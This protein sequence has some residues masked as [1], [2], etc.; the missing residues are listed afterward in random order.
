MQWSEVTKVPPRRQLRQFAVLCLVFFGGMTAWRAWRGH[1]GTVSEIVGVLGVAVGVVGAIA[2]AA[3]R[4]IYTGWM[5]AVFPIGWVVSRVILAA[6]YFIVFTP[7]AFVFR[8]IG[9]DALRLR[10]ASEART[11]WLEKSAPADGQ[12]YFRQF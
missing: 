2:P 3:I 1:L 9:R 8:L 6:L 11:L 4:W 12:A 10:R 7:V 5:I